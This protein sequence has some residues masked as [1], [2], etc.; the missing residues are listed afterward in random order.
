MRATVGEFCVQ[1]ANQYQQIRHK[2][3]LSVI[4]GTRQRTLML[5]CSSLENC[6]NGQTA[7][8]ECLARSG[9]GR[10]DNF[11]VSKEGYINP[12]RTVLAN[13]DQELSHPAARH[14]YFTCLTLFIGYLLFCTLVAKWT[15]ENVPV[16]FSLYND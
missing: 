2:C 7:Q 13:K 4:R 16:K 6:R 9:Y 8:M 5:Q 1:T 12:R 15:R 11:F 10:S 3:Q 14:K